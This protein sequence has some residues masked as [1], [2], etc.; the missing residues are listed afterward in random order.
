MPKYSY[1]AKSLDGTIKTGVIE[2]NDAREVA[3]ALH[4]DGYVLIKA[5]AESERK[6]NLEISLPSLGVSAKDRI[7]FT[8]NL[9]V[10]IASGLSLPRA[11]AILANQTKNGKFRSALNK[12]K[13]EITRGKSFSESIQDFPDIFNDFFCFCVHIFILTSLLSF[14][15]FH[16]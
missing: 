8:K 3:Q 10:M 13:E 14:L 6:R 15:S 4:H 11:I 12:V 16:P 9:Q 5:V 7:F 2:A 1:T